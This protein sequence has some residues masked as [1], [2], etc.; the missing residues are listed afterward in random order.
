[1]LRAWADPKDGK[2]HAYRLDVESIP[3]SRRSPR[4]TGFEADLWTL[5]APH[6]PEDG[7]DVVEQRFF[8]AVDDRAAV[9]R[10]HMLTNPGVTLSTNQ[11]SDWARFLMSLRLRQP[12]LVSALKSAASDYLRR[13][14]DDDPSQYRA[15]TGLDSP[16]NPSRIH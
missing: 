6:V 3:K 11:A 13:C 5:E 16:P 4:G 14:L 8:Q 7:R 12:H 1:M 9:V 15:V 10:D 2:V